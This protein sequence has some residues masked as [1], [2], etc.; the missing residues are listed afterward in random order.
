MS[1]S[2]S[3]L[4]RVCTEDV[5][6]D[7]AF[8]VLGLRTTATPRQVRRRREDFE[9]AKTLGGDAWHAMFKHLM[10]NRHVP[11]PQEVDEAFER[12]E[13]PEC[14]AVSEFFWPWPMGDD[15]AVD[16]LVDGRKNEAFGIW[17]REL[18][19][20]GKRRTIAQ[21]NL[22]VVY[23]LY[24]LDAE[25]QVLDGDGYAPPDFKAKML[26]YWEKC[27][28]NWEVL[29]DSDV[30]WEAYE[31]RMRELGDPRLTGGFV[32]RF[33]SEFPVAF[34]NINA[35]L[36]ARYAK[37]SRFDDAKRHVDYMSRTMSGLDDVQ[38]SMNIVFAPMEQRVSLLVGGFDEKVKKAPEQGLDCAR[39]LMKETEEIR[40]IAE[41]MLKDGQR[42]RT[43]IFTQIVTACNRYLVQ[44]GNKTEMWDACLKMLES[45][46][47]MACTPE[48]KKLVDANVETVRGNIKRE[49]ERN[50]CWVCKTHR[51]DC[52]Y[53]VKMYGDVRR[54]WG[55]ILWRHGTID[56][57]VCSECRQ[58]KESA[59]RRAIYAYL[60]TAVVVFGIGCCISLAYFIIWGLAAAV[61]GAFA[62]VIVSGMDD[63]F[64]SRCREHPAVKEMLKHGWTFG[65]RPPND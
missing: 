59:D 41:G 25:L 50:T 46:Q 29:A 55:Q 62:S 48:S 56:V 38:E 35:R 26:S 3:I 65:E 31:K 20:Y 60:I 34:D 45:L 64:E 57:P 61:V 32:R 10:G 53:D 5:Y 43:G 9:S 2:N 33:R 24:A 47:T 42:I 63:V 28:A 27:F 12:L 30:F 7:N 21:H 15:R 49:Q 17:E 22:A 4:M 39:R 58:K 14:R 40:R 51:A 13:D 36:A 54:E 52:R 44:Y 16:L 1:E 6:K 8:H 19:G 11:T 18:L 23:H 37:M